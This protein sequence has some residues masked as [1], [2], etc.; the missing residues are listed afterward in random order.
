MLRSVVAWRG[1]ELS[2][3]PQH[4][5]TNPPPFRVAGQSGSATRFLKK[6]DAAIQAI[7]HE[8]I[9]KVCENPYRDHR[10]Y[11]IRY[12]KGRWEGYLEYRI[13]DPLLRI[14]YRILDGRER[15]LYIEE[16]I[17]HLP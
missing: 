6:R 9:A 7:I 11:A 2:Q 5:M 16:I 1:V 4:H 13:Q 17:T 3:V 12:L 15:T 8:A 14:I 10:R